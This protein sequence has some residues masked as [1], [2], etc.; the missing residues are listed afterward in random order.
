M[1]GMH[2]DIGIADVVTASAVTNHE[3]EN[4]A[5]GAVHK[6]M[7]IPVSRRKAR[8]H[9]PQQDLLPGIRFQDDLALEDIDEFILPRVCVA[10]RRL[11]AR[12]DPGQIYAEVCKAGVLAEPA[13]E[14]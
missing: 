10:M 12:H 14:A 13:V 6:A 7:S 8:S 9:S 4:I 1:L 5:G 3:Q 11:A 2:I